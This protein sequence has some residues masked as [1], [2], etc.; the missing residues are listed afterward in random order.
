MYIKCES[1]GTS[2][3]EHTLFDAAGEPVAAW[4]E[5][6][7]SMCTCDGVIVRYGVRPSHAELTVISSTCGRELWRIKP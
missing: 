6:H 7:D 5:C 3:H 1:P 2:W 4:G